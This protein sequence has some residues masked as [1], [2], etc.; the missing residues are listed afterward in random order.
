M[1]QGSKK[2]ARNRKRECWKKMKMKDTGGRRDREQKK[3]MQEIKHGSRKTGGWNE[4]RKKGV[5]RRKEKRK[6]WLD[7][8]TTR[9]CCL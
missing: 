6:C 8:K 5:G 3:K 9:G 1:R 2:D 7:G 4:S